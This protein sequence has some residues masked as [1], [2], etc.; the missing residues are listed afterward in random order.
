MISL[1]QK[2]FKAQ[3]KDKGFGG[4]SQFLGYF[5]WEHDART[6]ACTAAQGDPSVVPEIIEEDLNIEVFDSVK[7]YNFSLEE[8]DVQSAVSKLTDKELDALKRKTLKDFELSRKILK[9]ELKVEGT[10]ANV[11]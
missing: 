9:E 5:V 3:L 2:V 6:V 10:N 1:I 8:S 4:G 7:E 11:S